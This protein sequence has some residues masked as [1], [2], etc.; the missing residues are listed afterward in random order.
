[1]KKLFWCVCILG[2]VNFSSA[3]VKPTQTK[4]TVKPYKIP[5]LTV[6]LGEYKD[7]LQKLTR[8]DALRV[9]VLPLQVSDAGK[10]A[11]TISS[12]QFIYKKRNISEDE[13][14][15]KFITP[16][17]AA[18]IFKTTPLSPIWIENIKQDLKT[19]EILWFID[20]IVK[21]SKGRL[22]FAPDFKIMIL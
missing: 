3:Q 2:S 14:G 7:T 12:Y 19:G 10:G 4:T 22:M 15:K 13:T 1:M 11:Y 18:Q 6:S 16:S 9:I 20:V 8:E 5:K 17:M 21:D